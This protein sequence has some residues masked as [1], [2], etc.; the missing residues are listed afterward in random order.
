LSSDPVAYPIEPGIVALV[1]AMTRLGLFAPCWSC[2]GHARA[3]GSLLKTPSVWF[4][5]DT[6]AHLRLLWDGLAKLRNAARLSTAWRIAVTFSDPDNPRTTFA[7]EPALSADDPPTL[8]QLQRDADEIAR[9]LQSI[10]LE[11]GLALRREIM[12]SAAR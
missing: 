4:N 8:Q 5:C 1:Y 7:L 12:S 11:A 6:A 2:E 3:D 9:A 10:M